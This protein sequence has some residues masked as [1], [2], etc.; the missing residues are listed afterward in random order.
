MLAV[1]GDHQLGGA[2]WDE[3][4]ALHLSRGFCAQNPTVEDPL[5]DSAGAQALILA[6]ERAKRELSGQDSTQVVVAH[7]GARA[8]ITLTR[9]ELEEMTAALLRRSSRARSPRR[10]RRTRRS[11]WSA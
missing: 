9:A 3:R 1:D 8:T 2:E 7:D 5:D 6:A 10:G 11:S 4:I